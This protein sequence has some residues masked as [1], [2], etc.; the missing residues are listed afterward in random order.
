VSK[1]MVRTL[2]LVLVVVL[3]F[4]MMFT[5]CGAK[6]ADSTQST[7]AAPAASAEPAPAVSASTAAVEASTAAEPTP[8][9]IEGTVTV[10]IWDAGN[11]AIDPLMP[12]F[13]A[14]YPDVDVKVELLT[15]V[16]VYKKMLLALSAGEGAPDVATYETSNLAQVVDTGALTDLTDKVAPYV[17]KINKFK[18][19]DATKDGKI[20]AMPWDSGPVGLYYNRKVFEK[21]GY[22][23]DPDSV[24]ALLSTWDKYYEAAKVIK[25]KTGSFILS[26]SKEKS[27]GRLFQMMLWQQGAWYVKNDGSLNFTGSEAVNSL[28]YL[29]KMVKE[30]YADNAEEWTQAWY[31]GFKNGRVATIP[32][33]SWMGGFLSGW[34]APDAKGEWGVA[35]LPAWT[36]GGIRTANDGG[37]NFVIPA[38]TKN[39]DAAWAF[40]EYFL[41]NDENQLAI[42]KAADIFP[43]LQSTYTTDFFNEK[44]DYFGGQPVRKTFADLVKQVPDIAYTKNYSI[45]NAALMTATQKV[46]LKNMKPED[47]L[48]EAQDE[49]QSKIDN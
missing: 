2:V 3:S 44:I 19:A 34:I 14:K 36:E 46:Y 11:K 4:S 17:D 49:V 1:K 12:A 6:N 48:K 23:S 15:N 32:A 13:K 28:S 39:L 7:S 31:D 47:A 25:Q 45:F 22:A 42:Y 41:G 24:S 8:K 20:Y 29:D 9:K 37:S 18:W 26:E 27:S 35:P 5:G 10:W 33:A 38:Q 43:S 16:D 21:A 30:G 40:V